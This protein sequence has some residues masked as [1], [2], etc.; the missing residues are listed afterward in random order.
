MGGRLPIGLSGFR[1]ERE[2]AE[3]RRRSASF[4]TETHEERQHL[5]ELKRSR[6]S[7][8]I[9]VSVSATWCQK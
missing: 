4:R 6:R 3:V 2:A 1:Y 7:E 8:C 5:S 9:K